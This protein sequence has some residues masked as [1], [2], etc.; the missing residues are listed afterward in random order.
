MRIATIPVG[1]AD[2]YMRSFSNK[3]E[4]LVNDKL[5][6]VVGLVCM[7][8]LMLD[9]S[10]MKVYMDDEVII[11]PDIYKESSKIN[12]IPYELMTSIGMRVPRVYKKNGKIIG[13]DNYLGE[14]YED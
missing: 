14:V 6:K 12:T 4:I 10:G 1:Y 5:C 11:Y 13:V 2:G 8:Q 9:A 7:D 3:G